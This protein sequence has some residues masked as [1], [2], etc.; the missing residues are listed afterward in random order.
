MDNKDQQMEIDLGDTPKVEAKVEEDPVIEIIDENASET[1]VVEARGPAKTKVVDEKDPEEA[2]KTLQKKLDSE[3]KAR[4]EAERRAQAAAGEV[5]E[6]NMHLVATAIET[7]SREQD[8]LK[9]QLR[10]AMSIGDFDKAA[11]IQAAMVANT[12][13][14]KQLERGFEEMKNQP[15]QPVQPMPR[16]EITV[17]DLIDKVTPRSA[18]WLRSNREAIPD[19]RAIRIMGRAHEDAIDMGIIPESDEYFRFV[20]GRLGIGK[21]EQRYEDASSGAAKPVKSRQSPPSAPV[22]REPVGSSSRPGTI[23]LTAAEV[24]AAKISG[25]SPAEYYKNKLRDQNRLN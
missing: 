18:E 6:T 8:M 12:T 5:S 13:N 22:S 7:V 21:Q 9:A 17:D 15:R 11:D 2:L 10:D 24:E 20:E 16:Q 25:I 19:T 3:R 4:E 23:R 1:P 14:L